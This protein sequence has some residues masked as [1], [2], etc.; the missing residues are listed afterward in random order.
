MN[1]SV[2]LL[3]ALT[4]AAGSAS[5]QDRSCKGSAP[6]DNQVF[7]YAEKNFAGKCMSFDVNR[8]DIPDSHALGMADSISSIKVGKA[9]RTM[10]CEHQK[11]SGKCHSDLMDQKDLAGTYVGADKVS[12]F[13]VRQKR[14]LVQMKFTN[15]SGKT[16]LIYERMGGGWGTRGG[17]DS[18]IG[19]VSSKGAAN[20]YCDVGTTILGKA[21]D[22]T[23]AG[24]FQIPG[25]GPKEITITSNAKGVVQMALK[26]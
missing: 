3:G 21:D 13:M 20:I 18:H 4:L 8:A 2:F 17:E 11:Y 7:F 23:I 5:A 12:S 19:T 25:E 14:K 22:K 10:V 24:G 1:K 16:V 6:A 9:A 15:T 26:K